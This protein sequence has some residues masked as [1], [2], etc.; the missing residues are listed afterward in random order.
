MC[1]VDGP[2]GVTVFLVDTTDPVSEITVTDARNRLFDEINRAQ[3]GELLE[4]YSLTEKAGELTPMFIGCKP[5][6]GSQASQWTANP[7]MIK[8][9]WERSFARPLEEVSG[10]LDQGT[11]GSQSPIM[12][13][14]QKIKLNVF[15]R[16]KS[17]STPRRLIIMSDMIE[18]TPSFSHY[19][20]GS[21]FEAFKK[22]PGY[23]EFRTNLS[24]VDVD[25]WVIDRG[26]QR[27]RSREHV[28]FWETWVS[29]NKGRL[30]HAVLLEGVNPQG[31]AGDNK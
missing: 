3:L 17:G 31:S 19:R 18:H 4:I 25:I 8:R 26:I 7:R 6:D 12:A 23:Y 1:P 27:F 9:D 24:G 10:K 22:S 30:T 16:Y 13:A 15:D 11:A 28:G 29:D 20:S 5:D 14:I 21:D 2:Y